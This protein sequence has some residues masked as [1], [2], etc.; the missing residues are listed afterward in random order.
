MKAVCVDG[1]DWRKWN[2]MNWWQRQW[3][4][5]SGKYPKAIGPGTDEV[6]VVTDVFNTPV[7]LCLSFVEYPGEGYTAYSFRPLL[8][9]E[10]EA[11]DA[12]EEEVKETELIPMEA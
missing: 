3:Y 5:V 2:N 1:S 6:C 4:V 12:I 7:G 8:G 10:Q 11:L 9:S